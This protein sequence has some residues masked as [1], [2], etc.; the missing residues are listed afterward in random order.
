MSNADELLYQ[1]FFEAYQMAYPNASPG[2][3]RA[4]AR[5]CIDTG[6]SASAEIVDLNLRRSMNHLRTSLRRN[7]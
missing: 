5:A 6:R 4:A 1:I 7:G 3:C 2:M